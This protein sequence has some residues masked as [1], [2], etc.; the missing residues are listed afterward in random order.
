[1][2]NGSWIFKFEPQSVAGCLNEKAVLLLECSECAA[3]QNA[4]GEPFHREGEIGLE[5]DQKNGHPG[6]DGQEA[7]IDGDII[8]GTHVVNPAEMVVL[9]R[10]P[11]V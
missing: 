7:Q 3:S 6:S 2:V 8:D 9:R 5:L 10:K 4:L 11:P 1:M